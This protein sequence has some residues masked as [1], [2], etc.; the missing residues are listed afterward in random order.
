MEGFTQDMRHAVR[1][2][3]RRPGFS[4]LTVL[5][6]ALGIGATTTMFGVGEAS[7]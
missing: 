7:R 6:L 5:T 2:L 4:T 3:L 1:A